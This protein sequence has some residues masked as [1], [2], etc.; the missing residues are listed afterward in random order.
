MLLYAGEVAG[1]HGSGEADVLTEAGIPSTL[2]T[3]AERLSKG[4]A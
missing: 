2:A 3:A 4:G 1:S